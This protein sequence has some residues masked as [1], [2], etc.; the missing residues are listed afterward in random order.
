MEFTQENI[1][2]YIKYYLQEIVEALAAIL[3]YKMLS[4]KDSLDYLSIFKS[5]LV[6]GAITT[7]LETYDSGYK[8][9]VKN[10]VLA[11]VGTVMIK[12]V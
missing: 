9:S 10:G 5:S 11:T 2:W 3:I 1:I 12:G 4:S 8:T 6:I 7:V